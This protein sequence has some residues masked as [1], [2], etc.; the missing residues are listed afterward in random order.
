MIT[1]KPLNEK[2]QLSFVYQ[3]G[4]GLYDKKRTN[5]EP[6]LNHSS[7]VDEN[8]HL[9]ISDEQQISLKRKSDF[10]EPTNQ[11]LPGIYL[12]SFDLSTVLFLPMQILLVKVYCSVRKSMIRTKKSRKRKSHR[13][14]RK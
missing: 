9:T 5:L 12:L 11:N 2:K 6:N 7:N 13:L 1:S 10:D 3:P 8:L 14:A 4:I